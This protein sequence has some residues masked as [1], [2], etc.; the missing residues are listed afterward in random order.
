M[1]YFLLARKA[2][3]Y[4]CSHHHCF[5]MCS[6]Y[7]IYNRSCYKYSLV[8]VATPQMVPTE[9]KKTCLTLQPCNITTSH[10]LHSLAGKYSL[11][12]SILKPQLLLLIW[13]CLEN[14]HISQFYTFFMVLQNS[15][16]LFGHCPPS[17]VLK[18]EFPM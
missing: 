1:H 12:L 14:K 18:H 8:T 11:L 2:L 16:L 9:R 10:F 15:Q 13:L 3:C 7:T 5:I 6:G 4:V 17:R